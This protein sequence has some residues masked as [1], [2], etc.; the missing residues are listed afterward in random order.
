[1][2][3]IQEQPGRVLTAVLYLKQYPDEVTE[4]IERK[5]QEISSSI[6]SEPEKKI[7]SF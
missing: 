4:E 2:D 5:I 6:T 7:F 3:R 1:M